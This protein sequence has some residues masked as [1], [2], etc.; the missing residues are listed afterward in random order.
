MNIKGIIK[1]KAVI[2]I[3][4]VVIALILAFVLIPARQKN[5][6]EEVEIIKIN[7][8]I[9][10]NTQITADMLKTE[11]T[12]RSL[13]PDG[14]I[15]DKEQV[16]GKYST[17]TIY[18]IDYITADK[19]SSVVTD[20]KLHDLTGDMMAVS[21]TTSDLSESVAGK[22]MPGDAVRVYGYNT[23]R[24]EI[25]TYTDLQCL[26]VLAVSN[27]QADSIEQAKAE[28]SGSSSAAIPAAVTLRVNDNQAREL[29]DMQNSGKVH[30]ALT[31]R[32]EAAQR[33]LN[34]GGENN[35]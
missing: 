3:V 25:I 6:G 13:V 18:P 5:S 31:G 33:L 14:A 19:L 7:K 28:N 15:T 32:G 17:C 29:I 8:V 12:A 35:G 9:T 27:N 11:K 10:N 24:K 22:L 20:S 16:I 23:E 21:V 1:S 2:G 30:C 4:C 26:E 34:Q